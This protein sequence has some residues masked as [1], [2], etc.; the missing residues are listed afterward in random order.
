MTSMNG[1]LCLRKVVQ[2]TRL[3]I[4]R[5]LMLS[6]REEKKHTKR[7]IMARKHKEK[8]DKILKRVEEGFQVSRN[9]FRSEIPKEPLL[10]KENLVEHGYTVEDVIEHDYKTESDIEVLIKRVERDIETLKAKFADGE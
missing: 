3:L 8:V 4:S 5:I 6:E 2:S 7:T 9:R 1:L 10:A